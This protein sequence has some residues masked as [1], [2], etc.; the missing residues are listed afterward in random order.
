MTM[1]QNIHRNFC[2]KCNKGTH[3]GCHGG[4]CECKCRT[5]FYGSDGR[6]YPKNERQPEAT[7]DT[8][9]KRSGEMDSIIE[10]ANKAYH[11]LHGHDNIN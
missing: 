7:P 5:H 3:G 11:K 1:F 8:E 4:D 10:K 2:P 9:P 6:V